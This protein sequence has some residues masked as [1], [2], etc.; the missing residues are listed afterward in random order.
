MAG[1]LQGTIFKKCDMAA[2]NP[3]GNKACVAGTCQHTCA[4]IERCSHK[5]TLRYS[6]GGKQREESFADQ[7]HPVTGRVS[8]GSGRK[9]A[10]DAQLKLAHDKRAEG[11]TFADPKAGKANFG[12]ACTAFIEAMACADA[13]RTSYRTVLSKWIAPVMGHMTLAQAARAHET[14]ET[15]VTVTMRHLD[16]S[17]RRMARRLITDVLD[18]AVR[19]DK[20]A[21]HK[22]TDIQ[23]EDNGTARHD[24]F[25]F[26]TFKQVDYLAKH[27]GIVIWLM[28]G[29]G[30]RIAEALAV[31][32]ADFRNGGKSLRVSGQAT[33][34]GR[35][36]V[37][38][39]HRKAGEYRDVPV[40]AWLWEKVKDLPE[41]PLCPGRRDR[42]YAIYAT[43]N[44]AFRKHVP[45]AGITGRFTAHSLRHVY[46]SV[47]L[48]EGSVDITEVARWLGHRSI[49]VT[50]AIYGHLLPNAD[51]R[52]IAALDAEFT[53]WS[54][55]TT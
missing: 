45:L 1:K 18:K 27:M 42:R 28:R 22:I 43:V 35:R 25:V 38:L 32:K 12:E 36:K 13:T 30:L 23:V 37:A 8:Y 24:D 3:G 16:P 7:V 40:P 6:V 9:L 14:V 39:K 17:R 5:W 48:V 54:S 33:R 26:P 19:Q 53:R 52:A 34:D 29:C 31:E 21:G 20:I 50:Y 47:M 51:E 46:A 44:D 4:N 10:Q 41:G 11:R 49:N 15:L 55:V 2:H